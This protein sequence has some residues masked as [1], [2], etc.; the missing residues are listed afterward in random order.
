MH[1]TINSIQVLRFVAA[2]LVTTY[3]AVHFTSLN[4]STLPDSLIHYAEFGA[5]GV[6]IFFVIS[7][8]IMVWTSRTKFGDRKNVPGFLQRRFIR[9][10]PI[11]WVLAAVNILLLSTFALGGAQNFREVV[12]A[13]FLAPGHSSKLIF[14]GWTLTFELFFYGVFAAFLPLSRQKAVIGLSALFVFLAGIGAVLK[15]ENEYFFVA[16]NTLLLEFIMGAWIASIMIADIR[17]P[18]WAPGILLAAALIGF[19]ATAIIGQDRLPTVISF[20]VP[21]MLLVSGMVMLEKQTTLP[22]VLNLFAPLGDSSYSLYL[23]HAML[24][25]PATLLIGGWFNLTPLQTAIPIIVLIIL[26]ITIS[27]VVYLKVERPLIRGVKNLL[28]PTRQKS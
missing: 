26:C 1:T 8:F 7:G 9:I 12:G 10:F 19:G 22:A 24:L 20:G 11:Y 6:H 17:L 14:V 25:P 18:K 15:P 23:I 4:I 2:A 13:I 28:K 16:T 27:H 5:S 21:S 3:H